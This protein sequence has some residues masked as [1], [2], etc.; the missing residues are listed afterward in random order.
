MSAVLARKGDLS[1]SLEHAQRAVQL[2]PSDPM[3]H[4]NL[5][6]VA[7]AMGDSD[8]SLAHSLKSIELESKY[9]RFPGFQPN[10]ETFRSAA[11]LAIHKIVIIV[12]CVE[13]TSLYC[14]SHF[15]LYQFIW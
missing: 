5:S 11:G 3:N 8:T 15:I 4:R 9:F 6:K 10:T 13:L 7:E 14:M 12:V 1:T 2:N